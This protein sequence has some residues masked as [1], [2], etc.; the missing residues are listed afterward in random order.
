MSPVA[1]PKRKSK[2]KTSAQTQLGQEC[3]ELLHTLRGHEDVVL[4]S[5]WSPDGRVLATTSVDHDS[6]VRSRRRIGAG[7]RG[8][9]PGR[10]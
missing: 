9:L 4:R 5:I 3:P 1:K 2:G 8:T 10:E 6:T 7:A